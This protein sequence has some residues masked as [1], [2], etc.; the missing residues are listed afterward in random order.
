[1]LKKRVLLLSLA[2]GMCILFTGCSGDSSSFENQTVTDQTVTENEEIFNIQLLEKD[3]VPRMELYRDRNTDVLYILYDIR[4]GLT[5]MHDPETGLPLTYERY[6]EMYHERM[7]ESATQNGEQ[8]DVSEVN[9][10]SCPE[11]GGKV[12]SSAKFC[13][14][15]GA[16]QG[17]ESNE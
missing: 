15:C 11:C 7:E 17:V 1:M 13:S 14:N 2:V 12:D 10:D 4:A 5:E 9:E 3:D 6:K 16:K 8:K